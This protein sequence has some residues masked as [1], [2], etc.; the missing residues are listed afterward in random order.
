MEIE[1]CM[2]FGECL[3]NLQKN[4]LWNVVQIGGAEFSWLVAY[5]S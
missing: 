1:F 2:I 3:V 4:N 5:K